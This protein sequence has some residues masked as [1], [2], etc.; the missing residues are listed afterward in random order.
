MAGIKG[1]AAGLG[2]VAVG[3]YI[4]PKHRS[5]IFYG[6]V[7]RLAY[8]IYLDHVSTTPILHEAQAAM[9]G[10]C[11][12]WANPSSPHAEGRAV[13]AA[14]EEGRRRIAA[15]LGWSGTLVF[16]S[17][18]TEATE[19][20]MRRAKAGPPIVS[21]LEHPAVLRCAEGARQIAAGGDGR[22]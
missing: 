5:A 8:R 9:A 4:G 1:N 20:V 14:L 22:I 7:R 12:F 17:G 13:R 15:A 3:A 21:A 19:I 11:A 18:A 16:T 10:A 6:D 2:L